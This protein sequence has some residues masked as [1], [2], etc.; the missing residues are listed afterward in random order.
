MCKAPTSQ[1]DGDYLAYT[2]MESYVENLQYDFPAYGNPF[3]Q[4]LNST[5]S[6][7]QDASYLEILNVTTQI[8]N[9]YRP[10]PCLDWDPHFDAVSSYQYLQC[11][12]LP[13]LNG[14]T[15][16]SSIWGLNSPSLFLDA[17]NGDTN[18]LDPWCKAAFNIS[19]VQGGP[20]Y[21]Q[22]L[23]LDLNTLQNTSR[24]LLTAG[25]LDPVTAAG[26]PPWYPGQHTMEDSRV[27]MVQGGAHT[28]DIIAEDPADSDGLREARAAYVEVM[29]AWLARTD[30]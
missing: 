3:Q 20:A 7:P 2:L 4:L 1:K 5:L 28:A 25:L 8:Q 17:S 24:L 30:Q 19:S 15:A 13:Q 18:L 29:K 6:L 9:T 12:Y 10:S 21:Q 23:G 14:Y 26:T 11:K 16:N 22:Q 27:Y